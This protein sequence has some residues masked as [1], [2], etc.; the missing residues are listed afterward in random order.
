M[1]FTVHIDPA[2]L[3]PLHRQVYEQL[4]LGI[5]SGRLVPGQRLPSSRR[6]AGILGLSRNTISQGYDQLLSEGYLQA[7]GGAGT[8]VGCHLPEELLHPTP[9]P[10]AVSQGPPIPLS[11]YGASLSDHEP[12]EPVTPLVPLSFHYGQP[13]LDQV[14]L[15][16]WRALWSKHCRLGH[17]AVLAYAPD[18][19]GHRPLREAVADYLGRVRAVQATADQ[20]LIVSGQMQAIDLVARVLLDRGDGVALEEPGFVDSR[21]IFL[22]QGAELWPVPVDDNGLIIEQL[23]TAPVKLVHLTPS[24]QFPTGVVLSLARRL[25][26]LAWAKTTGTLL[27]EEDYDSEYRYCGRPVPALQ[28]LDTGGNV[29]YVGGFTQALFP[30]LRLAYLVVP[31]PLVHVFARAKWLADRQSSLLEQYILTDFIT[32]GHLERHIRRMRAL[33]DQR[34]NT[35]VD[36]LGEY[37]GDRVAILG[38]AAG[39]HVTIRLATPWS[40]AELL[41]R[42]ESVGVGL[43]PSHSYYLTAAPAGEFVLGYTAL[44][45]EQITEGVRRLAQVAD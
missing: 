21:R 38:E 7:V 31:P 3:L 43:T 34:R 29:L 16:Q 2:S 1:D 40:E 30:A 32:E 4:R 26:L 20:I 42:A 5:L 10:N 19:Q 8:F 39:M 18:A 41:Q 12:F 24:H 44:T 13:D 9:P 25:E 36:A 33:Y 15:R 11:S 22:A 28:G 6:L 27:I 45:S 37:F 14:P 35:L 17:H 23:P